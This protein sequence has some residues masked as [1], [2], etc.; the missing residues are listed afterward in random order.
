MKFLFALFST[1][2]ALQ[3][4][5]QNTL[6]F[7]FDSDGEKDKM[8][9]VS[10]DTGYKL[11]YALSSQNNKELSTAVITGGGQTNRISL[12]KN[13]VIL[14][15]QFM[16]GE[17]MFKFRYDKSLK[18]MKLIGFDNT[19]YGNATNDGSGHSSYNLSTGMY[20]ANW[21]HFNMKKNRLDALP[22]ISKK[23]PLK[24]YGLKDFSDKTIDELY[25]TEHELLPASL[26]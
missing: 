18:D 16:R 10:T 12:K 7:D 23:L 24:T 15:S 9:L 21:N 13:V 22:K 11:I 14:E 26:K 19:Q 17:N 20:I 2:F 3:M 4:H 8:S 5:G 6:N 1:F 25:N